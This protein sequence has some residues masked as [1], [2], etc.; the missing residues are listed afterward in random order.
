MTKIIPNNQIADEITSN[1]VLRTSLTT[2]SMAFFSAV[3][4]SHYFTHALAPFQQQMIGIIEDKSCEF[5][6]VITFRGSGKSTFFTTIAPLWYIMGHLQKKHILIV[7]QTQEQARAHMASIKQEVEISKLLEQ[8]LGPFKP[9]SNTWNAFTLEFEK[10]QARISAVSI[11]QSVRGLRYRQHRP[12]VIIC[13]DIEDS[14]SVRTKEGRDRTNELYSSEIAPL[15]DPNTK[16]IMVGN[17]LHPNSLLVSMRETILAKQLSGMEMFVPLVN[18]QGQ[19]AWPQRFPYLEDIEKLRAR[20]ANPREWAREYLLKIVSDED[21]LVTYQDIHWYASIP[22][23]WEPLF[24]YRAVGVD[25]AIS[26][27]NRADYTAIVAAQIYEHKGQ[28]HIFIN[29]HPVNQRMDFRQT[30]DM[31][32]SFKEQYPKSALFIEST[33][34]QRALVQQLWSEGVSAHEVQIGNM[35]K[36]ERLSLITPWI[37]KGLVHFPIL[38]GTDLVNQVVNLG[39][40]LHDDLVD[41]LTILVLQCME[42]AKDDRLPPNA[43]TYNVP[44]MI[45]IRGGSIQNAVCNAV[46]RGRKFNLRTLENDPLGW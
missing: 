5:A 21:Q 24:R 23:G 9:T 1:P 35:S 13:D 33:G 26:K 11:D 20:I 30:I 7:C 40:E 15:G 19:I 42:Y 8:D 14:T 4:F 16:I 37:K 39:V 41:A 34:Y 29:P 27:E 25:L 12:E 28:H 17:Y 32:H 31:L 6:V 10:Y 36:S 18:D 45:K 3:Y 2:Q 46:T 22:K 38:G 44:M 43:D